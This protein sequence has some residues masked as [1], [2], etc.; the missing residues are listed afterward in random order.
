MPAQA[1]KVE[2]KPG[3]NHADDSSRRPEVS[4]QPVAFPAEWQIDPVVQ[5]QYDLLIRQA[6]SY[7]PD[8]DIALIRRAFEFAYAK[9]LGQ[10]RRSG[11]PY[12]L[13]PLAVALILTE[14]Q[15]TAKVLVASLLH[16][17]VEDCGVTRD[18][19]AGQFGE[20]IAQLVDGVTKLKLADFEARQNSPGGGKDL[21]MMPEIMTP[22]APTPADS[23]SKKQHHEISRSAANLRKILLAMA[24]DLRVMI[25]KLADRLHNMRTLGSLPPARQKK[26]A[27]ET[28]QIFA[29]LAHRLGMWS[30]KWQLE[31]LAFKYFDPDAYNE[32]SERVSRTRVEREK[33]IQIA[34]EILGRRLAGR[35]DQRRYQRTP[36]APLF[37]LQQAAEK[38]SR[39]FRNL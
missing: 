21:L 9:H 31:D 12:I 39:F 24:R 29:P 25:I 27:Q 38:G 18:E 2:Q 32:I 13:H 14:L 30:V 19:I 6:S 23:S 17:V 34:I 28:L 8:L 16:D 15:M 7:D 35:E 1:G 22:I 5:E 4:C 20:E 3:K 37:D 10:I 36:K 33:D 11:E 26:V